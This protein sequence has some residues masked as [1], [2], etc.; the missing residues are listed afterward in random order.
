MRNKEGYVAAT[1]MYQ[2][3]ADDLRKQIELGVLAPGG[4]PYGH[5]GLPDVLRRR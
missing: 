2:Q 1:P 3:I 5:R 4:Q